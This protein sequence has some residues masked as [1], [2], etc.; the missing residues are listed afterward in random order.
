MIPIIFD[1]YSNGFL[2]RGLGTLKDATYTTVRE[3]KNGE[4][5]LTLE[6][7]ISG[8]KFQYI[9]E[10][11]IIYASTPRGPQPFRIYYTDTDAVEGV[12]TAYADHIFYDLEKN[13]VEDTFIVDKNAAGALSQILANTAYTTNFTSTSDIE[14]IANSRLVRR[15]PVEAILDTNEENC[16]INRWGGEL[17]RE[18]YLIY[19]H[20]RYGQDRGVTVKYKKNLEGL[21]VQTNVNTVATWIMPKGYDGLLLPEKYIKSSLSDQ[22]I[23]PYIAIYE[24]S[25]IKAIDEDAETQDEDALPLEEA[26]AA[27]REAAQAL[28]DEQHVDI[29]ET[30]LSINA[31]E[32][33]KTEEYKERTILEK[34]YP[35]DT[36]TIKH[37]PLGIDIK[38]DMNYYEWDSLNEEYIALEFGNDV[39][40]FVSTLN[41][42]KSVYNKVQDME[43]NILQQAKENATALINDGLGGYVVKTQDELL[44]MNTNNINTATKVWRWNKNGLGYSKTGY[45]GTFG[46]AMTKDGA[47]VAD[48]ITAGTMSANRIRAGTLTAVTIENK[49]SSFQIDLSGTGGATCYN[50]G[51]KSL[52]LAKTKINFY[53][54]GKK[55]DY[56]G[57]IGSVNTVTS[58]YPNGDPNKPNI[59][60][61]NDLDSSV[62][63]DYALPSGSATT[64]KRY[65][66]FDKYNIQS[67]HTKPI[68]FF[69]GVEFS[70]EVYMWAPVNMHN[71]PIYLSDNGQAYIDETTVNGA[72]KA[73]KVPNLWIDGKGWVGTYE[74]TGGDYAETFEWADGNP[75]GEDRVGLLVELEGN[76]IKP[77]NGTDILGAISNTASIVG[78][79]ANEWQGKYL[80]DCFG[81]YVLDENGNKIISADYDETKE[82]K[83]RSE[84]QEWGIVG[85]LGKIYVKCYNVNVG[86]YVEAVDG[87]AVKSEIKTNIRVLEV[88]G[89]V[90]RVLIK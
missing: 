71:Y 85:L 52:D 67:N 63:I 56:I 89:D 70:E 65:A 3:R 12:V 58:S 50:N 80:K 7:P 49:D 44:I 20:Q 23:N 4:Y 69:E 48:F 88:N 72:Y 84:R 2:N 60:M 30:T 79:N 25:D 33:S 59:S 61:W 31:V 82:Y 10:E 11:N 8:P 27:L 28:Y 17:E 66:V 73:A 86:D 39:S 51:V 18:G 57:S 90:A 74:F 35:F 9:K 38:V 5:N 53:N 24:F 77:A 42:V 41:N 32:L 6:Y 1:R 81:R 19:L 22:Y 15:N 16:I 37:E 78:D 75:N 62:S 55:G 40:S 34:I 29:P 46:L 36:V 26:Y 68:K 45:N 14:T 76:K 54:W 13:L 64:H 43:S 21:K 87:I 83:T 47:I